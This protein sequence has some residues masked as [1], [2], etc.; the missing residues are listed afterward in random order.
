MTTGQQQSRSENDRDQTAYKNKTRDPGK[1][2]N[3][4][5]H[6]GTEGTSFQ[7]LVVVPHNMTTYREK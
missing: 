6:L 2:R 4:T 1:N 3:D 7:N 5:N